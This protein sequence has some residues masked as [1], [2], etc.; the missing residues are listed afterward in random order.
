M[1]MVVGLGNPG[2]E[3]PGT[4]HNV[5]FMILDSFELQFTNEKKFNALICVKN[6]PLVIK[7]QKDQRLFVL[8]SILENLHSTSFNIIYD[9]PLIVL[10]EITECY[11][12]CNS[13]EENNYQTLHEILKDVN[14]MKHRESYERNKNIYERDEF[15]EDNLR[16][17]DINTKIF[18][19]HI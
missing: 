16:S 4:R 10:K 2:S 15:H 8:K 19:L 17:L 18:L 6:I 11:I 7:A 5:G 14:D 1:K 9:S 12:Y 3:Y 13:I